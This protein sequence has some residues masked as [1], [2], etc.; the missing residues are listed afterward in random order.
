MVLEVSRPNGPI[1]GVNHWPTYIGDL[2]IT[3][4]TFVEPVTLF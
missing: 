3:V 2:F 1:E 4:K